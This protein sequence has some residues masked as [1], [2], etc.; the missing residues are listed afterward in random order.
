M[1]KLIIALDNL[2][3]EEA[4]KVVKGTLQ[5]NPAYKDK[6][7]FKIH[8][9]VSLLWFSWIKSLFEDVDCKFMLDPKWHDIPN[10]LHNYIIQLETSWLGNK[11]EYITLHAS[12]GFDMLHKAQ[13]SIHEYL[14]HIKL[15]AITALTS[16]DDND[17][18]YIYDNTALHSV[19]R[20]A[21][22]SLDAWIPWIVCSSH[23]ASAL[24]EVY[25]TNFE[26]IT[27]GIRF[28]ESDIWDQKRVL[29]PAE[30]MRQGATNIVMWRPIIQ[31]ENPTSMIERFFNETQD[32][33]YISEHK[34]GFEKILYNGDWKSI[35]SYIWAF[36][37]RPKNG[38]YVRFTS[39]VL[40]NAY[41]NIWAI[42]RSYSVIDRATEELARKIRDKN[43]KAD[44]V[45]WAQMGSVRISLALAKKLWINQSIY[46]EKTENNNNNM[47]LKRHAVDLTWINIILSEDIVS[48]WTTI[49]KMREVLERLWGKVVAIACVGNRFEQDE[50]NGIPII[51]C[52]VP[53]KFELYWDENTPEDQRKD[54][55]KIPD[56]SEISEKPK[57]EWWELVE[58]MRS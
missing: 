26:I 8:D 7:V 51:S 9:I 27:P 11:V 23:E 20:L 28:A 39:K 25:G 10:T 17:T 1:W 5:S 2:S 37:F 18:G 41:I 4:Y 29:T 22:I 3:P 46:T 24:R 12:W 32:V 15:L 44:M 42:E 33:D 13:S 49:A 58:S 35:L 50:Q 38:K 47:D 45:V 53:P 34:Y 36:Y 30:A 56:G 31:A 43:I 52:F 19:L 21:K 14:P 6:I 48:R 57:N 16:L 55:P 40:S 54:F